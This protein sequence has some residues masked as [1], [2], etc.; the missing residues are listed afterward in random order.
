MGLI[1]LP[2]LEIN[3]W[4][5]K[6]LYNL[7]LE[8]SEITQRLLILVDGIAGSG[9]TT[10]AEKLARELNADIIHT[11]DVSWN[12]DPVHWDGEMLDCIVTPWL[13]GNKI[14]Y[15]PTGWVKENRTGTIDIDPNKALIIEGM[16]A[17]R[18]SL[19]EFAAY[20][21]WV[22]TEPLIARK[23]AVQRDIAAGAD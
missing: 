3:A 14:A 6:S 17:S 12:A 22:D 5:E 13:N 11:D 10:L 1:S 19:R 7:A 16:G 20:S 8:I 15:R 2:P 18:K 9:K 4:S 21:I 23:R